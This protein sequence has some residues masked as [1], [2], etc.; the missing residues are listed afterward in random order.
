MFT[1]S[2]AFLVCQA[3]LVVIWIDV[4]NLAENARAVL[5]EDGKLTAHARAALASELFDHRIQESA[6]VMTLMIW[7][8]VALESVFHWLTR[9]WNRQTIK[10]HAFSLLFFLCP[11]FRMCARSPEMGYRVWLPGLGWRQV[12]KRLRRRLERQFSVPMILIALM[13]L[14]VLLVDFFLKAQVVEHNWLRMML[15][16]STGIIWFAFAFEFILMVSIADKK[17]EYCK[18]HWLDIAIIFMPAVS[19]LRSLR[20]LRASQVMKMARVYRL[21]ATAVRALRAMI[22]LEFFQRMM[23]SAPEQRIRKLE[24]QLEDVE[25]EAKELRRRIARLRREARGEGREAR[26]EKRSAGERGKP[27]SAVAPGAP[28][29]NP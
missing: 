19:F 5:D 6:F 15:H 13:I 14:P 21:R 22:I 1:L 9:P 29:R 24:Q 26:N 7:P 10:D 28:Q 20:V 16:I 3:I 11:S 2:L 4:P 12:N 27:D 25:S 18:L 8:I 17:L 23:G